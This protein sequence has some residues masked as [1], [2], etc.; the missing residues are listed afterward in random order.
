MSLSVLVGMTV[1]TYEGIPPSFLLRQVR[2]LGVEFTEVTISIFQE[3]ENVVRSTRGLKIGLHLPIISQEG[4][5]FS[6]MEKQPEIDR[7][8]TLINHN[9]RQLNLQYV[10]SHPTEKHLFETNYKISEEVLFKNLK[11]LQP[12]LLLENTFENEAFHFDDFLVRADKALGCQ[13]SG[14]C[15]DGPHAFISREDWFDLLTT[16][17][18]RVRLVHL[19]DCSKKQD[20]HIPFGGVGELPVHQILNYL[21]ERR[22]RGIVNLEIMPKSRTDMASVLASYLLMLRYLNRKKYFTM[23]LRSA[24]LLW[25]L[26]RYLR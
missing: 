24:V 14:L 7:L 16:Y 23:R 9:W 18:D 26:H 2:R 12:P 20:L 8:I 10:L 13:L 21:R 22:Y 4:Y 5:D 15:F 11:K 6:C 25:L 3:I 1:D 17:F 19:S